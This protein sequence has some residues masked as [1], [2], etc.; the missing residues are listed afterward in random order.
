L[1]LFFTTPFLIDRG[2]GTANISW[3]FFVENINFFKKKKMIRKTY[4]LEAIL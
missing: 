4:D 2:W 3:V 1:A